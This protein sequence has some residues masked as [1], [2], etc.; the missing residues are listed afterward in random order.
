MH[1]ARAWPSIYVRRAGRPAVARRALALGLAAAR[2]LRGLLIS[3]AQYRVRNMQ[4]NATTDLTG[5][6]AL[7]AT[8]FFSTSVEPEGLQ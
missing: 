1:G 8:S 3:S 2:D 6:R 7:A 4:C 5:S